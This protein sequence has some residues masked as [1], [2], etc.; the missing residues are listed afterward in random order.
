MSAKV[1][2]V[3]LNWNGRSYLERFLPSVVNHSSGSDTS[4]VI[5]DNNSTDDSCEFIGKKYPRVE[6][7]RFHQNHGFAR[8]YSL[9]LPQIA[10]DY[11]VLLNSDVEVTENWLAPMVDLMERQPGVAAVMPRIRSY[12]NRDYF[13]YAGAAGGFIDRYGYPFCRGRILSTIERDEGQYDESSEIFWASGACMVLRASAYSRTGGLDG[14]FF[15]H[16]EEI[17]LCWRLKRLGY[18]I[19]YCADSV[20]YHVGGGTLPNDNPRKLYYNYRNSL[21]LLFKNVSYSGF[22]TILLPR[23]ILDGVSAA[24]YL[25]Q[26]KFLFAISVLRAHIRFYLSLRML[27]N[28][29]RIFN[30]IIA[31]AH[32]SM[33]YDGSIVLAY[34]LKG[35]RKYSSLDFE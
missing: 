10:A 24:V 5:V 11:Y 35:K 30:K 7:I 8:G 15:A 1:A 14:D 12:A 26:G 20:V 27:V 29:R 4:I 21:Y 33:I 22:F 6:L 9:A 19:H 23:M 25:L 32:V 3:I 13:E 16:M 34:F 2:V 28:K 31:K 18:S 17:D